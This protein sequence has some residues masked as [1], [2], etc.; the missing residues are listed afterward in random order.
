MQGEKYVINPNDDGI[1]HINIYSKGKIALGRMLSNFY[2]TEINMPEGKFMSVEGYWHWLSIEDCPEKEALRNAYGANAKMLGKGLR[3]TK[4]RRFDSDFENK[5]IKA[6]WEKAKQKENLAL[7]LPEYK[8][9]PFEHYYVFGGRV[10][11][12]KEKFLWM[13][14]RI[15]DMRDYIYKTYLKT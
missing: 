15:S 1:T 6:I 5:I 13:I 8:N 10:V 3:K 7:F 4:E 2:K 14:N 12:A 11:D 9:L